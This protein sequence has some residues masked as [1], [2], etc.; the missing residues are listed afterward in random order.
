MAIKINI[1]KPAK[2]RNI[3]S[4]L[5]E[6]VR[7]K[8]EEMAAEADC[9]MGQ[10]VTHCVRTVYEQAKGGRKTAAAQASARPPTQTAPQ[11]STQS[12]TQTDEDF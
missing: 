12:P 8:V 7:A 1:D 4:N 11:S 6:D 10:V 5:P 2:R 3:N 9:T